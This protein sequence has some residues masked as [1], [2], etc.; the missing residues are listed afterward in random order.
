[1]DE[2]VQ[3]LDAVNRELAEVVDALAVDADIEGPVVIDVLDDAGFGG[4]LHFRGDEA[5]IGDGPPART[6]ASIA[7][8]A[9]AWPLS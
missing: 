5:G 2:P 1:M 7:A 6:A 8:M 4:Q 9:A 3:D